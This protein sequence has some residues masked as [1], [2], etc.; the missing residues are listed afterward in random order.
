MTPPLKKC[1]AYFREKYN[2]VTKSWKA[3]SMKKLLIKHSESKSLDKNDIFKANQTHTKC[4]ENH[5]N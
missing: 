4:I 1:F 2:Y 3:Y 5:L